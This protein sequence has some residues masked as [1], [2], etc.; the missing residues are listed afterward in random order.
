[1]LYVNLISIMNLSVLK[2][3]A[4]AM[5]A[6]GKGILAIDESHS[7]CA[8]RFEKLGV[9]C[10]EETRR[11]YRGLLVGAPGIGEYVSGM[12]LFDE[13]LRQATDAG[14]SFAEV[15][16][17]GGMIP[18]IKVDTGAKDLALHPGEM[19]TEGLDG[20]RER[21]KE[22]ASLGAG[23]AKW[24]AVITIGAGLPSEAC[25]EANAHALA[26]YAALCQEAGIVPMV[27][28]EILMEG[29]HSI[30]ECY[31][32]TARTLRALFAQLKEQNVALEGTILK[33][34]MVI[35][36]T[37]A[38]RQASPQE[39]AEQTF[40]CLKENVPSELPGIVFLSGGQS[41]EQ[42]TLHLNLINQLGDKP[43]PISF[44]YGRGIQAPALE[45]WAKDPAANV[46]AAQERLVHWSKMN[47]QAARGL[48][49]PEA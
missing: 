49:T 7:T 32:A 3:T 46:S 40:K 20:L 14:V 2:A 43:W 10:T 18:G 9:P 24:R 35:S 11:A 23:F 47:S 4:Q 37:E 33:V 36:G 12:I 1:M 38:A 22:Y 39:V 21:L 31:E 34:S 41:P 44:S 5:V 28:P 16:K 30:E 13:T 25:I 6:P 15:L 27:E 42:S 45:L 26:R 48:Y 8:K 19:V 29:S 17:Q